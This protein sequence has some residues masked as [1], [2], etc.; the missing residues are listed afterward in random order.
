MKRN[1]QARRGRRILRR[2]VRAFGSGR[3]VVAGVDARV[4]L[5]VLWALGRLALRLGP[6]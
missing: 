2:T 6:A 5:A 4:T 3:A 1:R